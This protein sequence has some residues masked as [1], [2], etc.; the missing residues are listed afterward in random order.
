MNNK[1]STVSKGSNELCGMWCSLRPAIPLFASVLVIVFETAPKLPKLPMSPSNIYPN[2]AASMPRRPPRMPV[3]EALQD[4]FRGGERP[5]HLKAITRPPQGVRGQ[6]PPRTV[7]KFDFFKR[8][9]VLENESSFQKSQ[10][11]S[12]PNHLFFPK[13]KFEKLNIFDRNL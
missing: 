9:K 11:F 13:K 8:C 5:G 6:R 10:Y 2:K 7:A 12:C 1:W 4:F 3:T